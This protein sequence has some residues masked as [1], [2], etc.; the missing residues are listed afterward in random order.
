MT[1]PHFRFLRSRLWL[2]LIFAV[3]A[4]APAQTPPANDD[5]T[6]ALQLYEQGNY[7]EAL[8]AWQ[9]AVKQDKNSP[10]AWHYLG[11]TFE[12]LNKAKDARKA[13]EKAAKLGEKLLFALFE[14][15]E[16]ERYKTMAQTL[17]PAFRKAAESAERYLALSENLDAKKSK[18]WKSLADSLR[19]FSATPSEDIYAAKDVTVKAVIL[20]KPAPEY[21]N[22][23]RSNNTYGII[24]LRVLLGSNGRVTN[25]Q[26]V[27]GLPN[28]LNRAAVDAAR[29]IKFRPAIKDGRPVSQWVVLQY[30]FNIY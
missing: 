28:G 10:I 29:R 24:Q 12:R 2:A 26:I 27:K 9:K 8:A 30:D 18:E 3:T 21:T 16:G 23:A 4:T 22:E 25:V 13:H 17:T 15:T 5:K 14:I 6:R 19:S 11:L 1:S 7:P 20:S